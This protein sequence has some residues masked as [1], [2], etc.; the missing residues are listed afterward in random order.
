MED[1]HKRTRPTV[2][3]LA[4]AADV[5]VWTA[6]NTFSNP[7]RV[8]PAT[9]QRVLDAADALGYVGPN[10]GARALALGRSNLVALATSEPVRLLSDPAAALIAQGVLTVCG[11]AG[12][13]MV[14]TAQEDELLVDGRIEFRGVFDTTRR[15]CVTVSDV[16]MVDVP[17]ICP[18]LEPGI[19]ALADYLRVT[20]HRRVAM[21]SVPGD[22][23]R[24]HLF[25]E[26]FGAADVPVFRSSADSNWPTRGA[27]EAL[28]RSALRS[29][30]RP[31]A[32]IALS[33]VVAAGA[34]DAAHAL[35]LRVPEDVTIVGI[36][37]TPGGADTLGLTTIV[38]PYR[39]MG[40]LAASTLLRWIDGGERPA[41]PPPLPTALSIRHTSGRAPAKA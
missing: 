36:D 39:P 17:T 8:A 3:D 19:A 18:N 28:A 2:R 14:L 34:L 15:P 31:T 21:L 1:P 12:L 25:G 33:D 30:D 13:S 24:L 22:E 29:E 6:S 32:L 16:P 9:R 10:P 7:D 40:E 27:G 4:R 38:V 41:D 20:G 37:D 26:H 11:R 23:H 5:S 35:G